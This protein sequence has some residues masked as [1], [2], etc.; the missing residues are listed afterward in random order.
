LGDDNGS[1]RDDVLLRLHLLIVLRVS[2]VD[3]GGDARDGDSR[4]STVCDCHVL[5]LHVVTVL[6]LHI[7]THHFTVDNLLHSSVLLASLNTGLSVYLSL[8]LNSS[9]VGNVSSCNVLLSCVHMS[10][11]NSDEPSIDLCLHTCVV[12]CA[13]SIHALGGECGELRVYYGSVVGACNVQSLCWQMSSDNLSSG[14]K[15]GLVV[16]PAWN[17]VIH[18]PCVDSVVKP[19]GHNLSDLGL[20]TSLRDHNRLVLG[21]GVEDCACCDSCECTVGV[22]NLSRVG[23]SVDSLFNFGVVDGVGDEAGVVDS[24]ILC[25]GH[26]HNSRDGHNLSPDVGASQKNLRVDSRWDK[27]CLV[28]LLSPCHSHSRA[29]YSWSAVGDGWCPIRRIRDS[30]RCPKDSMRQAVGGA[31][32]GRVVLNGVLVA[33]RCGDEEGGTARK[34]SC[35]GS[36]HGYGQEQCCPQRDHRFI[37]LTIK[38]GSDSRSVIVV[39][40]LLTGLRDSVSDSDIISSNIVG[41]CS[42]SVYDRSHDALPD[43]VGSSHGLSIDNLSSLG[44][45]DNPVVDPCDNTVDDPGLW[46]NLCLSDDTLHNLSPLFNLVTVVGA[47]DGI[48]IGS[49]N[50]CNLSVDNLTSSISLLGSDN[51][52]HLSSYN[53]SLSNLGAGDGVRSDVAL[54]LPALDNLLLAERSLGGGGN[55]LDS[56]SVLCLGN[57][58]LNVLQ[59]TDARVNLGSHVGFIDEV[60]VELR[61]GDVD[62]LNSGVG[63]CDVSMLDLSLMLVDS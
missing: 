63:H 58:S 7:R 35:L 18:N 42:H 10:T 50:V 62:L 1:T 29:F 38:V 6:C 37:D 41:H 8:M 20:N 54:E 23:D 56:C 57:I 26:F 14:N 39:P 46:H 30:V 9:R 5:C 59:T 13:C 27:P 45:S 12:L 34:L 33:S 4:D 43:L 19:R 47:G 55:V 17:C 52:L 25:P 3:S 48:H 16:S 32:E 31:R 61:F 15:L 44:I 24:V 11:C 60:C 40:S 28:L 36:Q 21:L 49:C 53:L 51:I 2:P 22:N